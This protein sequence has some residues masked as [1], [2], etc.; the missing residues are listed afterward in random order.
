MKQDIKQDKTYTFEE[1]LAEIR[2]GRKVKFDQTLE[3]HINLDIDPQKQDQMVRFSTTL[4]HGTGKSIKVAVVASKKV[5]NADLELSDDDL[6]KIE[7]GKLQPGKDFDVIVTEPSQMAKLAKL[8][9]VL[10]PAGAMPNPKAGTVTDNVEKA[11]EQ[12][13][14]GKI[15]VK[16]E[17]NHPIIHTI[18]GKMSFDD[19]KLVENFNEFISSL[20]QN[21]PQ[22]AKPEF[23]ESIFVNA[24]MGKSFKISFGD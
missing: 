8:G 7:K 16:T 3:I 4:P 24:T 11:V 2:K 9:R 12:I 10:G 15:N 5:S 18:I 14:K 19:K 20:K 6:V 1:A 13:K 21:K 22:K 17:Q 23:I